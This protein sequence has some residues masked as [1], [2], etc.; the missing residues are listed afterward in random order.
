MW[1]KLV[2]C[3]TPFIYRKSRTLWSPGPGNGHPYNLVN[4]HGRDACAVYTWGYG[5]L[6][7]AFLHSHL[8]ILMA[9][10]SLLFFKIM[11]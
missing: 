7:L 6:D 5:Y 11:G 4:A 8:V 9:L 3:Q 1:L 2:G 10:G